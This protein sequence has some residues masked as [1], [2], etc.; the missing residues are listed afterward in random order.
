MPS[1]TWV[2]DGRELKP[3]MGAMPSNTWVWD[4]RELKPKM[5]A[6]P[7]NT[8]VMSGSIPVPVWALVILGLI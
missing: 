3:K 1:N 5:G 8:W 4:G 7:S 6:M 2:W